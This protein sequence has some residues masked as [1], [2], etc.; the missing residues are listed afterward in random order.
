ML[1]RI[2]SSI[3]AVRRGASF[4]MRRAS[5][6]I[7]RLPITGEVDPSPDVERELHAFE[8]TLALIIRPAWKECWLLQHQ[9]NKRR[10]EDGRKMITEARRDDLVVD[11]FPVERL[12]AEGWACL[13]IEQYDRATSIGYLLARASQVLGASDADL[14][15]V[16]RERSA[17]ADNTRAAERRAAVIRERITSDARFD[18]AWAHRGRRS[19]AGRSA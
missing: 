10:I 4:R 5:S 1:A 13:S 17:E 9:P 2:A 8:P 11:D 6:H 19:V 15:A 14:R 12:M 16:M 3:R 18:H 7:P